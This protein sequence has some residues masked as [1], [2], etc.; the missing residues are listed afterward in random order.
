MDPRFLGQSGMKPLP[1]APLTEEDFW[2]WQ[3][4]HA[5]G[6]V[7]RHLGHRS[8]A[9]DAS[10]AGLMFE[11]QRARSY[12]FPVDMP[13][14]VFIGTGGDLDCGGALAEWKTLNITHFA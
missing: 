11:A 6:W 7:D 8:F 3:R 9:S 1:S 2:I 13:P 10:D 14:L 12:T 4:F 5:R